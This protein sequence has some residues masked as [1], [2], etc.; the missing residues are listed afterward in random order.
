MHAGATPIDAPCRGRSLP[1]IGAA[2]LRACLMV[3]NRPGAA[4]RALLALIVALAAVAPGLPVGDNLGPD[5]GLYL[6]AGMVVADGGLPYVD[7]WEHKPP[8]IFVVNAVGAAIGGWWGI[9]AVQAAWLWA[10]VI[11]VVAALRRAVTE[12]AAWIGLFAALPIYWA[13]AGAGN[14]IEQ[15]ALLPSA[16]ALW[17]LLSWA[18]SPRRGRAIVVAAGIGA[19]GA[20]AMLFRQN[21]IGP[22]V[23]AGLVL[24]VEL[25]RDRRPLAAA[26]STLAGITGFAAVT[27]CCAAVLAHLGILDATVDAAFAFNLNHYVDVNETRRLSAVAA[28]AVRMREAVVIPALLI[29][30]AALL[31]AGGR[32]V[33]PRRA[34][35]IWC[36]AA[37]PLEI[38]LITAG[39]RP[40]PHYA[41]QLTLIAAAASAVAWRRLDAEAGA[42]LN[43]TTRPTLRMRATVVAMLGVVLLAAVPWPKSE[44]IGPE[45]R[46]V[47]DAVAAA[48]KPGDTVLF[49]GTETRLH[50]LADR[51]APSRYTFVLP[52]LTESYARSGDHVAHFMADLRAAPPKL[53]VDLSPLYGSLPPLAALPPHM[54]EFKRWVAETYRLLPAPAGG[55]RLYVRVDPE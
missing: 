5:A 1:I 48:S 20:V 11:I 12:R 47:V 21:L 10:V 53:L 25:L 26:Q 23:A 40:Y 24:V 9:W 17:L 51:R 30:A 7:V 3:L 16:L 22:A 49:W 52:L 27:G 45:R 15:Y 34:A 4:A 50:V 2:P 14:L 36:T 41:I 55:C 37:L 39:A 54:A 18:G 19:C 29:G 43:A 28:I 8:G 46:A 44:R 33:R 35:A 38:A 13:T 32:R 31:L 42:S 6:Y